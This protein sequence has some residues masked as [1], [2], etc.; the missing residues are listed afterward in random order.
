M[1]EKIAKIQSQLEEHFQHVDAITQV[2]LKGHLLIEEALERIIG[3]F[4]FHPEHMENVNLRF[5]QKLDVARSMSLDEQ[6]NEMWDLAKVINSLRNELAHS[7]SSEKRKQKTQ[8]VRDLYLKLLDDKEI[9]AQHKQES[10]E[11]VLMWAATLILGF[12]T[13]FESEVDRFKAFVS[14]LERTLNIH[15][16]GHVD[17]GNG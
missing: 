15:R 12:L 5:A 10:D 7:L 11:V 2:V 13:S 3:K 8:R 4:V 14:A 16:H 9:S 6:D 17:E 1:N